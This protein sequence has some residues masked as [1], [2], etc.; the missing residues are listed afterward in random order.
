MIKIKSIL[1]VSTLLNIAY[2][3]KVKHIFNDFEDSELFSFFLQDVFP[4]SF[5]NMVNIMY[6]MPLWEKLILDWNV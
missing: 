5:E 2:V 1:C 6:Y 4:L 3:L